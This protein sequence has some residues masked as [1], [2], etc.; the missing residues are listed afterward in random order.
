[1]Y[2]PDCISWYIADTAYVISN[3]LARSKIKVEKDRGKHSTFQ[4]MIQT[5]VTY[6]V[7]KVIFLYGLNPEL[8]TSIKEVAP[9]I[10]TYI[11]YIKDPK[12]STYETAETVHKNLFNKTLH[13]SYFLRCKFSEVDKVLWK[14]DVKVTIPIIILTWLRQLQQGFS[15]QTT[16]RSFLGDY[17]P[18]EKIPKGDSNDQLGLVYLSKLHTPET[19]QKVTSYTDIKPDETYEATET[20]YTI[21]SIEMWA[22]MLLQP[23]LQKKLHDTAKEDK[24]TG[25]R[26]K[27]CAKL[28]Q[29]NYQFTITS[30]YFASSN[31]RTQKK[32]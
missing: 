20:N 9:Q 12:E 25:M 32:E 4:E 29:S 16:C 6:D 31:K 24:E 17:T 26:Q 11:Q 22:M 23:P 8:N 19:L 21:K 13:S 5:W 7:V 1:L 3:S 27:T 14:D 10:Q 28:N 2:S 30:T 18:I 15:E